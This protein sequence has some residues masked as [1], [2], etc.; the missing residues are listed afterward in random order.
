MEFIDMAVLFGHA[1]SVIIGIYVA[2]IAH[3]MA[4]KTV[5]GAG[6]WGLFSLAAIMNIV[7]GVMLVIKVSKLLGWL[8]PQS[9]MALLQQGLGLPPESSLYFFGHVTF[10]VQG[11][12]FAMSA[13]MMMTFF[14]KM[15]VSVEPEKKGGK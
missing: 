5:G 7:H 3:K 8:K 1:L 13:Y 15:S 2:V 14:S 9:L 4:Q 11:A 6:F 10:T 12:L